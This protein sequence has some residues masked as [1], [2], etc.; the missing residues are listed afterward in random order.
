[1]SRVNNQPMMK[2]DFMVY[3]PVCRRDYRNSEMGYHA[4][5]H[6]SA[7]SFD[8]RVKVPDFLDC[9]QDTIVG[10]GFSYPLVEPL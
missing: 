8:F 9:T 10:S 1:M 2:G 4:A 3:C 5:I 7:S 6:D